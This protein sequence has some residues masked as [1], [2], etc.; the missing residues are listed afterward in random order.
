MVDYMYEIIK[1]SNVLPIKIFI[2]KVNYVPNHWHESLELLFI[3]SGKVN[4]VIDGI[5]YELNEE[6]VIVINS[7]EIHALT[8][9]EDNM[10]LALQIP[11]EYIKNHYDNFTDISFN[12]KSFMYQHEDQYRFNVIKNMLAEMMWIYNKAEDGFELKL[13]SLLFELVYN[14]FKKFK[15]IK[16]EK[17]NKSSNKYLER[18]SRIIS[19]VGE[20]YK[21]KISLN[22]LAKQEYLSVFYLSKF[23]QKYM[24]MNFSTYINSIRL[25][26]A[27]KDLVY[28]DMSISQIALDNGF[29]NE[30]SFLNT[31]K[32]G[33]G[34]TPSQYR[35]KIKNNLNDFVEQKSQ[36]INYLELDSSNVF[37]TLFKYLNIKNKPNRDEREF[38]LK[39]L[40]AVDVSK[41]S[42]KI[43]HNWKMLTTIGKAKDGLFAE[44]QKQLEKIQK[45]IGFKY[46]RF[47]GIFD[48]EMMVY[49]EDEAGNPIFNFSYV[50]KLFDFFYSVGLKPFVELGFMPSKL[51]KASYTAFYRKSI[52]SMPKDI[53]KWNMLIK[54]FVEHCIYRYGKEEVEKWYF[55]VWNEPELTNVF[56]FDSEEDYYKL[57]EDTYQ[58]IKKISMDIKVGGPSIVS[59]TSIGFNWLERFL[60]FCNHNDCRPDFVSFHSYPHET[61]SNIFDC[62][63]EKEM[64]MVTISENE[65]YLAEVI[66]KIKYITK[67]AGLE[68][69]EI[70]MTEWNSNAWHRDLCND[71]CYKVAYIVKNIVENMDSISSFAY[72]TITDFIE[73]F[74]VPAHTFHGGLGVITN[75]G[76]KKAAYYAFW[77][78]NKLGNNVIDSGDGY[79]ITAS[80]KGYQVILYHYCHFDKLYSRRDTSNIHISERY[81]VFIND[82]NKEVNLKLIGFKAGLYEVKEYSV[83]RTNGSSY[84]NWVEMGSIEYLN[85]EEIH[86]LNDK[87]LP[88]F[89]KYGQAIDHEYSIITGLMPHEVKLYEIN[90][91]Q[92]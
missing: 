10:I 40:G 6:D 64:P 80:K 31:F 32:E 55:E 21:K 84:D 24:G 36:A 9:Q 68:H 38:I 65:E 91:K 8:S 13:Q 59:V 85:E 69:R 18:L 90:F 58:S 42:R 28:A 49:D 66:N 61:N 20:N 16:D 23:F 39:D 88:S 81:N 41:V 62:N 45:D 72:W 19:Y 5:K 47:H 26:H 57:Y 46:I 54:K 15:V 60:R 3:L 52:I 12:C 82:Y 30:K 86:Y 35:K 44:V 53:N 50:D 22:T 11:I 37:T 27:A 43:N 7:N 77:L 70:H 75:N 33:Y 17:Q 1:F 67:E 89:K 51:A 25:Q 76:I 56:W 73:E 34:D 4:I 87:S 92:V 83:N 2:H 63:F 74:Q 79:Y 71:T 48:D 14:L 78:L 29:S